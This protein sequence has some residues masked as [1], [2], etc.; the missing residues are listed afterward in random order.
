MN[1]LSS[2]L[3]RAAAVAVAL[4]LLGVSAT[5]AINGVCV[6]GSC[7]P[8]PVTYGIGNSQSGSTSNGVIVGTDT[9]STATTFTAGVN[10]N[11]GTYL[12]FDPTVSYVGTSPST[13][14]DT[15]TV[16][17]LASIYD[18]TATDWDGTYSEHVPLIVAT[19]G[20]ASAELFVDGQGVGLVGPYGAGTY[21]VSESATLTG[22]NGSTLDYA[23]DFTFT[24][25][26]GTAP[27]ATSSSPSVPEPATMIPAGLGLVSFGLMALRRRKK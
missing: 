6:N 9:Y 14:T 2:T 4:P 1:L 16:D 17:L 7:T 5:V 22:V 18:P 13:S 19:G 10:S 8:V 25:A 24:F 23:Y 3:L 11:G 20:T 26:A 15:I 12:S 21:N 27:G